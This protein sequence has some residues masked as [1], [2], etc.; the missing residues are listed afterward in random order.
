MV[1]ASGSIR[2]MVVGV[3]VGRSACLSTPAVRVS[4]FDAGSAWVTLDGG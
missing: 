4:S 1:V 2:K 3:N